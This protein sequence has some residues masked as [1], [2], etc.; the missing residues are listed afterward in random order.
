MYVR[1]SNIM[2][3]VLYSMC[4]IIYPCVCVYAKYAFLLTVLHVAKTDL[5][6]Y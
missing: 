1:L 5:N 3:N 6:V 2:Y 4:S